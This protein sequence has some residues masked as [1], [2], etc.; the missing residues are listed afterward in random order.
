MLHPS[1]YYGDDKKEAENCPPKDSVRTVYNKQRGIMGATSIGELPRSHQQVS[2]IRSNISSNF[3]I[4]ST[5]GLRDPL[6]MVMEQS[7]LCKSGDKFVLSRHCL[8]RT[9]VPFGK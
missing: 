1:Q 4:C 7:K 9:H 8:P 2:T 5:K 3:L 6:L